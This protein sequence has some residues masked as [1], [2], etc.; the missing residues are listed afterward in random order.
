MCQYHAQ[1]NSARL[2][3]FVNTLDQTTM[4]PNLRFFFCDNRSFLSSS[5]FF[6]VLETEENVIAD[7]NENIPAIYMVQTIPGAKGADLFAFYDNGCSSASISTRGAKILCSST[8]RPGPTVLNVAGGKQLVIPH[9]EERF[10]LPLHGG[11]S[12]TLTGLQM[13]EITD[14]FPVWKLQQAWLDVQAGYVEA[15]PQGPALPEADERVGVVSVDI[16]IGIR[17]NQYFPV[18]NFMLPSGL[19]VYT[20]QFLT[21]SGR[22]A[23]LGGAHLSWLEAVNRTQ[24]MDPRIYFSSELRAHQINQRTLRFVNDFEAVNPGIHEMVVDD[25]EKCEKPTES[26]LP[27]VDE[28]EYF[29]TKEINNEACS[30]NHCPRHL[31]EKEWLMPDTW[32]PAKYQYNVAT[33]GAKFWQVENLGTEVTYRCVS[34]RNCAKCRDGDATEAISLAEEVD[35]AILEASLSYDPEQKKLVAS[36]PFVIDPEVHLQPNKFIAEKIFNKQ[37]GLIAK[38]PEMRADVLKSHAK[39]E[40]KGYIY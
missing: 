6:P 18:L 14:V 35:A 11:K 17:Y 33:D 28:A 32:D 5:E 23:I 9:G 13:D 7:I 29:T 4:I 16:M 26:D 1:E 38:N 15:H 19:A 10:N 31:D 30:N 20:A 39:L 12:A 8:C 24:Y 25:E 3:Q 22:R 36:L 40:D 34:C 2:E 21:G 27:F 37:M